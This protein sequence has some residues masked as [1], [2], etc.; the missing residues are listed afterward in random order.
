M[1]LLL[2]PMFRHH[3]L[4]ASSQDF[5]PPSTPPFGDTASFREFAESQRKL[6]GSAGHHLYP[7][8]DLQVTPE[9]GVDVF[10]GPL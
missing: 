9:I 5:V 1:L 10:S 7:G 4:A 2:Q 8:I 6:L 3:R